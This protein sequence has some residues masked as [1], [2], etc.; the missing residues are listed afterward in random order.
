MQLYAQ[1]EYE[2][3]N[4]AIERINRYISLSRRNSLFC[5]SHQEQKEQ[6]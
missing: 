2:M 4:N 3:D 1:T 5:G 6:Y